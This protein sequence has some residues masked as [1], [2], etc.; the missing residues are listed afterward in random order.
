MIQH[1]IIQSTAHINKNILLV[2]VSS[3]SSHAV[4]LRFV[5]GSGVIMEPGF[6]NPFHYSFMFE[7]RIESVR[8][9]S[10]VSSVYLIPALSDQFLIQIF[11]TYRVDL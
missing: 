10:G 2:Q 1:M 4:W 7:A 5:S 9:F 3:F 6:N 11:C 8:V